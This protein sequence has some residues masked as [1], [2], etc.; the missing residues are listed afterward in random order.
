MATQIVA[1]IDIGSNSLKLVVAEGDHSFFKVIA[2][3][4]ERLRLGKEIQKTGNVPDDL[5]KES[6]AVI[7]RFR[8]VAEKHE[9]GEILA[10]ATA[11]LRN[12][13][14]RAQFVE[15]VER[16]TDIR[17]QVIK[18]LEEARLI[19]VSASAYFGKMAKSVLNIDIGGGSTELSL[20]EEGRAKKLFSM[21]IGAVNLTERCIKS[22]PPSRDDLQS[23]AREIAEALTQ[24]SEGLRGEEWEVTSATSGTSMHIMGLINFKAEG[25]ETPEIELDRLT[26]LNRILTQMPLAD[27]AKL[28]GISAQR[29]E[30]IIAGAFILEGVMNA[31]R[32]ESIKPCGYSLREGV[33]IDYFRKV[34]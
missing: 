12:A 14:N 22:D 26:G 3:D 1:A 18:P 19:G 21:N 31:L 15:E 29:A 33:V 34:K 16:E 30:V 13:Q 28:P 4:R 27:R 7:R 17:I 25:E 10:V 24:P 32:I 2:N 9:A 11:S 5:I 23:L 6:V 8:E 20:F